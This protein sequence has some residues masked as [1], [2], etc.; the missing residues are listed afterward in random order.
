MLIDFGEEDIDSWI[1]YD[2]FSDI[3]MQ[4]P[5]EKDDELNRAIPLWAPKDT[6]RTQLLQYFKEYFS[7]R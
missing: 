6:R 4:S 5:Y 3:A 2:D 7:L 1:D